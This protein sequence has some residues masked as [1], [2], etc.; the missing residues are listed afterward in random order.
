MD[1]VRDNNQVILHT[2]FSEFNKFIP[3]LQLSNWI[4]WIG[5]D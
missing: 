4:M 3:A 1:F 2:D 5:K